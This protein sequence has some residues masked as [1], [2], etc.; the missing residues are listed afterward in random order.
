MGYFGARRM[1]RKFYG[2]HIPIPFGGFKVIKYGEISPNV[3]Y[4]LS[5]GGFFG[6]QEGYGLGIVWRDSEG[7]L[8]GSK[9]D[10]YFPTLKATKDY[11]KKLRGKIDEIC[12]IENSK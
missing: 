7:K 4:E 8:H 10:D 9:F 3:V 12:K 1:I 11:I 5:V 2:K 6:G